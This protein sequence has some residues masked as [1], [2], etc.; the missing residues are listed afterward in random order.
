MLML[1]ISLTVDRRIQTEVMFTGDRRRVISRTTTTFGRRRRYCR[2]PYRRRCL[3]LLLLVFS[4]AFVDRLSPSPL[5][6]PS[7]P[8]VAGVDDVISGAAGHRLTAE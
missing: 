2:V 7:P 1:L 5:L 4:G 6:L 8:C 3:F